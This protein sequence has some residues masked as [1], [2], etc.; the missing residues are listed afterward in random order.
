MTHN[1]K[2]FSLIELI[3]VLAIIAVVSAMGVTSF[4]NLTGN[5]LTTDA[6]KIVNDLGWARQLS[7]AGHQNYVNTGRQNYIVDFDTIN[8]TYSVYWASVAA[9]NLV[10]TQTLNTGV[11]LVSVT[12]FLGIPLVPARLTFSFP[13]G[14]T[15][16]AYINLSSQ[17]K[18]KTISVFGNTGYVKVQ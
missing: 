18:T 12:D 6:R 15:Q 7:V 13:S 9:A 4:S 5:R 8:E 16:N 14:T 10:K 2:S 11:D 17:G 3:V 1:T